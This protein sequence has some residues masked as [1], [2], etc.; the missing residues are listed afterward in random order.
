MCL[1]ALLNT[2]DNILIECPTFFNSILYFYDFKF[3]NLFPIKREEDGQFDFEKLEKIVIE[4]N[5]KLMNLVTTFSNPLGL[6][7]NYESR[8][9][10]Y[11]LSLKHKFYI[12]SDDIY[13]FLYLDELAREIPLIFCDGVNEI[14]NRPNFEYLK[15]YKNEYNPYIISLNSFNKLVGPQAKVG[16][17]HCHSSIIDKFLKLATVIAQPFNLNSQMIRSYIELGYMDSSAEIHRKVIKRKCQILVD[18]ISKS[19]NI[20]FNIPQG[21]YFIFVKLNDN[22]D[23]EKLHKISFENELGYFKGEIS[24]LKSCFEEGNEYLY[25]KR[26]VRLAFSYLEDSILAEAGKLFVKLVDECEIKN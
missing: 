1:L 17:I 21:G 2:N 9:K 24:T 3:K 5:I 11:Q 22:I 4:K 18:E 10:L 15:S 6:N 13:E 20:K 16:F 14:K 19:K 26:Y 23:I 12:I 25:L 8:K 7:L